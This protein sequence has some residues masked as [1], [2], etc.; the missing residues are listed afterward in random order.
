MA[1]RGG[2]KTVMGHGTAACY[3]RGCR[4]PECT[5]AHA[6]QSTRYYNRHY[7]KTPM[8]PT[9]WRCPHCGRLN[10]LETHERS[11]KAVRVG[12]GHESPSEALQRERAAQ[13]AVCRQ[14][15]IQM[16]DGR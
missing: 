12:C 16:Q 15:R 6:E 14:L 2:R 5:T 1:R 11:G 8:D 13:L 7:A 3:A 4:C 10:A 9:R